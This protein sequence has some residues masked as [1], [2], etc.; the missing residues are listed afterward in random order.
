[1]FVGFGSSYRRQAEWGACTVELGLNE[2]KF[3][4]EAAYHHPKR[5]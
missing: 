2:R 3:G 1:M 5:E 4:G